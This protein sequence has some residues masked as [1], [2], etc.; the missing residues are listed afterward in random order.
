MASIVNLM[1][2]GLNT[3]P[4]QLSVS[5]GSMSDATNVIIRRDNIVESRRGFKVYGNNLPI[6]S[7]RAKQL[8]SY[9][10]RIL[11][12]YS[13]KIQF[14]NGEE[15][16]QD[17]SG[18]YLEAE[19]GLRMKSIEA[20]GNFY[21]TT[22]TG[23][24]KI[25]A[26]TAD[27]FTTSS[28]FITQSGGIK[29]LDGEGKLNITLGSQTGFL[30]QDSAV[31]YRIVW[32]INDANSNLI[33]GT[34]SSRILVYN[35]LTPLMLRDFTRILG[36]LDD[37][38]QSGSLI[39]DGDYILT[40][41]LP[42]TATEFQLRENLIALCSKLDDDLLFANDTGVGAPLELN[43]ATILGSILT[44][45]FS[46]GDA[47]DYFVAG[48]KIT[49]TGFEDSAA[50][51][52]DGNYEILTVLS[53][54][55]TVTTDGAVGAGTI[56]PSATIKSNEFK[57][58]TQPD[59]P[60][61]TSTH[62]QLIEIQNYLS[63]IL[64][65]LQAEPDGII[66]TALQNT[67]I[68]PIDLTTSANVD[69]TIYIPEEVSENHFF[70]IYRSAVA[71][72]ELGL[73]LL[74]DVTPS[75]ELQLVYEAFPTQIELDNKIIYVTDIAPDEF[76]GTNLYT[77]G[78]SGE[79]ILQA[80][81]VPPFA[82]DINRF[83]NVIF[84]AN[85]RTKYKKALRLLGVQNILDDY[86]A[87][88]DPRFIISTEDNSNIY[89][90]V[91]GINEVTEIV[92]TD[93]ASLNNSGT[94][95]YWFLNTAENSPNFYVW[96]EIGTATDPA[97]SGRTG[98][99]IVADGTE[100]DDEIAEKT[101][102]QIGRYNQYFEVTY[103]TNEISVLNLE[104]AYVDDATAETSGF[105]ITVLDQGQGENLK[106]EIHEISTVADVGGSLAGTYIT[107]NSANNQ[108]QYYFWSRV[109]G[110]GFDP[111]VA[112]RIS[113][114][115][116]FTAN[117]TADE[118]AEAF[119]EKIASVGYF[120]TSV[121]ANDVTVTTINYG[122]SDNPGAG[123]SGF[124]ITNIQEGA[125]EVLLSNAI[126]PAVAVEQTTLSLIKAINLNEGD[127]VYA[128]YLSGALD[129]PGEFLLESQNLEDNQFYLAAND[130]E[131]GSSFSPDISGEI[132]IS[133]ISTGSP[134]TMLITTATNHNLVNLDQIIL[135]GTNS[136]PV[137]DGVYNITYVSPTTFRIDATVLVAGTKGFVTKTS[138]SEF[139]EN[140]SKGNRIYYSKVDQ[141]EAVPVLNY[142]DVGAS[143][144]DILRIFPLR[145]SL[146]VFKEDGLFRVSGESAPFN[147]GLFDSSF[148]LIA[149]DSIDVVN[150]SI[151]A[152]VTEGI[153][154]LTEAGA[155]IISRPI[156]NQI[157]KFS[158]NRYENF[159][160]LT[161]GI[162]YDS[163]NAYLV[164]TNT[165]D[166]DTY[167]TQCYR[168][169]TLTN[170]WTTYDI[171]K[172]CGVLH[173]DDKLY[174]GAT[175]ISSIEQERKTFERTDYADREYVEQITAPNYFGQ[176]IKFPTITNFEV[177]DV[178]E[179]IQQLSIYDFNAILKKL[180]NDPGVNDSDYFSTLQAEGGD[181]LRNKII[182][183]AQ[184]LDADTGVTDTNYFDLIDDK[185]GNI[186][187]IS[188]NNPTVITSALHELVTGRQITIIN[189]DS[190]PSINDSYEVTVLDANTFTID[191]NV[192]SPG[193]TGSFTTDLQSFQ[194]VTACF[195]AMM[196]KLNADLGVTFNNY[197][198]VTG[199]TAQEAVI[200]T[201]NKV[202]K[203]ITLN[204]E[205]PLIV[206]PITVYKAI[207]TTFTYS[208]IIFEDPINF[209]H[210]GQATMMFIN[211]A[212]TQATLSF[213]T[214]LLPQFIPIVFNGDGNGIFGHIDGFG[215]NFFGGGSNSE[216][217]RT[218]IPRQCQRCRYIVAKFTHKIAREQYG[219]YGLSLTGKNTGSAR[220]YR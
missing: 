22:S 24:K 47:T 70:Q 133:S 61:T 15:F 66:P 126:S 201:V 88:N 215:D 97:I 53:N 33:L 34:P 3:S 128:F 50:D 140:E 52:L 102:A 59:E 119:A 71:S 115:V 125:L 94:A 124:T 43:T 141:P 155:S 122:F 69:L 89:Y 112:N 60:D 220:A 144:K 164:F 84:Y 130:F 44:I 192:S 116:D 131:V 161:W 38:N 107:L 30:P 29:A 51:P 76:R 160:T 108:K 210:I 135:A 12:H 138:R 212:F 67:Y 190:T 179:Q 78:I 9:K 169:N 106:Q 136:S 156:D 195:N 32:G 81:D 28:G 132:E 162:G 183:L 143:D 197:T 39:T 62:E 168:F 219:V 42:S 194:D 91:K 129:N 170:T 74:Q 99:K 121:V 86:D 104:Q 72:A 217:F 98:I 218:Y 127:S 23:V 2:L 177:G 55:I 200:I 186:T 180:D 93:G 145:D 191:V 25:S 90:F 80:N 4:N 147:L 6:S 113:V 209:K 45:N 101:V 110:S 189:S 79:G 96:Y 21:L 13:N 57:S 148:G 204:N 149:P 206:G 198:Q 58:I 203:E 92:T 157:L 202:T 193:T 75:D 11:R 87:G 17:F 214:D 65:E 187:L 178:V 207:E 142:F 196:R 1:A 41:N 109:S 181:N 105:T 188:V 174:L 166:T 46:T 205:M 216:P 163:D 208:P 152:W 185:S 211:K 184:K 159:R 154:V 167:A 182:S 48:D 158:S 37:I 173:V 83:K 137:L 151:Y 85:T 77:N 20:N 153:N 63:A 95:S 68:Q 175:D 8:F 40:L 73:N 139:S 100:T 172:T 123:T 103:I 146:F 165:K 114:P 82:K 120:N 171:G 117:S 118:V 27:D 176:T 54:E 5:P 36:A 111:L 19:T 56:D 150:N 49:L 16:F 31:A 26:K 10:N 64:L 213:A 18:D 7:D 134:S 14:E 35:P 199:T